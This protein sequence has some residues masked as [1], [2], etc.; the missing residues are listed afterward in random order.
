MP[1]TN[2]TCKQ[3]APPPTPTPPDPPVEHHV[4]LLIPPTMHAPKRPRK[5]TPPWGP[6]PLLLLLI[7]EAPAGGSFHPARV[8]GP[9]RNFMKVN[10]ARTNRLGKEGEKAKHERL[11]QTGEPRWHESGKGPGSPVIR[12]REGVPVDTT[13]FHIQ[14]RGSQALTRSP[15]TFKRELQLRLRGLSSGRFASVC[16]QL[17]TSY[18]SIHSQNVCICM[19]F[20]EG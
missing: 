2:H 16:I 12:H 15:P 20:H 6:H 8:E 11:G 10:R 4:S 9:G 18:A 5:P 17:H 19:S 1:P 13:Q 7:G 14:L 3:S